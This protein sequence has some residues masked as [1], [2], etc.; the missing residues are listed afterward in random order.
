MKDLMKKPFVLLLAVVMLIASVPVLGYSAVSRSSDVY[1]GSNPAN[2]DESGTDDATPERKKIKTNYDGTQK[3]DYSGFTVTVKERK[4][5]STVYSVRLKKCVGAK[6]A[7]IEIAFDDSNYTLVSADA[8]YKDIDKILSQVKNTGMTDKLV[9]LLNDTVS[10][11]LKYGVAFANCLFSNEEYNEYADSPVTFDSENFELFTFELETKENSEFAT[12][13]FTLT[14]YI[15]IDSTVDYDIDFVFA[16]DE[17]DATGDYL[18]MLEN[19][20]SGVS[21]KVKEIKNN[22]ITYSVR[23][24]N[25]LGTRTSEILIKYDADIFDVVEHSDCETADVDAFNTQL[26]KPMGVANGKCNDSYGTGQI[27]IGFMFADELRSNEE[28]NAETETPITFDADNF[29]ICTLTLKATDGSLPA[30]QRIVVES[31]INDNESKLDLLIPLKNTHVISPCEKYGHVA[32]DA[33]IENYI[34]STCTSYGSFNEVVYCKVCHE[35]MSEVSKT[36]EMKSHTYGEWQIKVASTLEKEG[37]EARTCSVCSHEETRPVAKLEPVEIT[38]KEDSANINNRDGFV[39][40]IP[41]LSAEEIVS[42]TGGNTKIFRNGKEVIIDKDTKLATGMHV[43]IIVNG[44]I[45]AAREIVV[46][47]DVD[48]DG[49]INVGDARLALRAA[50]SLDKVEGAVQS[51]ASI[52][53]GLEENIAVSD[54]RYILRAAVSLDSPADWM[55]SK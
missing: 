6:D 44:E 10:G 17:E 3:A 16:G 45:I 7:Y 43:V 21:V 19:D 35:K 9:W 29:E 22:E 14:G 5:N 34:D 11:E 31:T 30:T 28:Y 12:Q 53:H 54:A 27:K 24:K 32:D 48:C 55:K 18:R 49:E 42:S 46:M 47:G 2:P 4:E 51:A 26:P 36:I 39:T 41:D 25:L 13:H 52:T 8:R 1:G 23:L 50:V 38:V 40:I 37:I 20:Y 15:D 33:V